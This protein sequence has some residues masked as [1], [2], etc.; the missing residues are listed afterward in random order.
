MKL[1][2]ISRY[3]LEA[4]EK[5]IALLEDQVSELK[6]VNAQL[7]ELAQE[8]KEARRE[9]EKKHDEKPEDST[10]RKPRVFGA[11]VRNRATAAATE[12]F[13]KEGKRKN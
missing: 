13:L 6:K 11:D 1:P 8:E 2:W 12:R 7:R 9:A 10:T 3:R 4:A 5:H